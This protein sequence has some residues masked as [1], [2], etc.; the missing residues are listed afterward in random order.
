MDKKIE[1]FAFINQEEISAGDHSRETASHYRVLRRII[2][3][4]AD[5]KP[6]SPAD[7]R[8]FG[9]LVKS[10]SQELELK[11]FPDR[12]G[13]EWKENAFS[14]GPQ[15]A[16]LVRIAEDLLLNHEISRIKRCAGENCDLLFFD[17]SKNRSRRWCE[18]NHCGMLLKSKRYYDKHRRKK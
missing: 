6:L 8:E 16:K 15:S 5:K 17:C 13:W 12:F 9:E 18:M 7:L 4:V 11:Q 14:A 10:V 1:L 2:G 3:T